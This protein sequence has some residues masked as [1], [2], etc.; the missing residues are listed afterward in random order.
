MKF[1]GISKQEIYTSVPAL[2]NILMFFVLFLIYF[3]KLLDQ[4]L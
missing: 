1:V 4:I 2:L 3:S